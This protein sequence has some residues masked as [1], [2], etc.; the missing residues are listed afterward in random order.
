MRS[1]RSELF[2]WF[3]TTVTTVSVLGGIA[4][5]IYRLHPSMAFGTMNARSMTDSESAQQM[6]YSQRIMF[7]LN[8]LRPASLLFKKQHQLLYHEHALGRHVALA[9]TYITPQLHRIWLTMSYFVHNWLK[10]NLLYR[11]L[12]GQ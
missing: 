6:G 12:Q 8:S 10:Y 11:F 1:Y 9:T 2:I 5:E 7:L 3:F 4:T